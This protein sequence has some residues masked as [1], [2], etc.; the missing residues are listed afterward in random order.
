MLK[1]ESR[2]VIIALGESMDKYRL[3]PIKTSNSFKLLPKYAKI[4]H[5]G[6]K[7]KVTNQGL[8]S[9][10]IS[11]NAEYNAWF[12]VGNIGLEWNILCKIQKGSRIECN[13]EGAK[14]KL[15]NDLKMA[16]LS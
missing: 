10:I 7:Y 14:N 6:E 15:L 11:Y 9:E 3:S 1:F 16:K 4:F 8:G 12:V 2:I 5:N 13:L